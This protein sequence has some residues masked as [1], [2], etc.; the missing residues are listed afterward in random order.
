MGSIV[1]QRDA[2]P[3]CGEVY[4]RYLTHNYLDLTTGHT[5]EDYGSARLWRELFGS[6]IVPHRA[7]VKGSL[8]KLCGRGV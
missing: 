6:E 8:G 4:L 7:D 1:G 3:L 5:W 2:P